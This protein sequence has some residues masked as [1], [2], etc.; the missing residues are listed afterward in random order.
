MTIDKDN[1]IISVPQDTEYKDLTA[2]ARWYVENKGYLI[3][4]NLKLE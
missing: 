3:Q 2:E 1:K 4:Y